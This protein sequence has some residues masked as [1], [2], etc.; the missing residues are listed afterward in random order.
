MRFA[1][2]SAKDISKEVDFRKS[3]EYIKEAKQIITQ[4]FNVIKAE[5]ISEFEMHPITREIEGGSGS[6]N[7]SGTLGGKGNLFSFIGFKYGDK[8]IMPIR[9][10]LERIDIT[11][12]LTRRDGFASTHVLYPT[13]EDIFRVTPL[14]WAEGR[15][16]AK[17]IEN[18]ISNFGQYVDVKSEASRSSRG[19][20]NENRE[21]GLSFSPTPYI[22][23]LISDFERKIVILNKKKIA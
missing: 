20:Q 16:W 18:G 11:S 21:S 2:N 12:I 22:T 3:I 5:L 4:E 15:S 9:D 14:P 17:G 10:L 8:P 7:L 19:L 6:S 1:R 13:A 23:S